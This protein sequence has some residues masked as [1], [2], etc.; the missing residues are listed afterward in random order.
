MDVAFVARNPNPQTD[1]ITMTPKICRY[2]R[3]W[4]LSPQ[5]ARWLGCRECCPTLGAE[6]AP[7]FVPSP[8]SAQNRSGV[9]Y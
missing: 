3:G 2:C 6:P 9:P 8:P 4:Y 7:S 5:G 1:S